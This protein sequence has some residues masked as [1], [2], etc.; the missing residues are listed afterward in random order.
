MAL[1]GRDGLGSRPGGAE[2]RMCDYRSPSPL[3][4]LEQVDKSISY[5]RAARLPRI[6]S[7]KGLRLSSLA[8]I[9]VSCGVALGLAGCATQQAAY[10]GRRQF[11][12]VQPASLNEASEK[13]WTRVQQSSPG[14]DDPE[15]DRMVA[16]I[17]DRLKAVDTDLSR[18]KIKA[19]VLDSDKINAFALPNG[20][21]GLYR[22]LIRAMPSV[23]ALAFVM[24]HELAHILNQHGAE[25]VSLNM[26]A[27]LGAAAAGAMLEEAFG[28]DEPAGKLAQIALQVGLPVALLLP[29]SREMESEADTVGQILMS[30]AGF[31][32]RG[33][34][35]GISALKGGD[36]IA[37]LSTHPLKQERIDALRNGLLKVAA[38]YPAII[39]GTPCR[40][41]MYQTVV[42]RLGGP[43]DGPGRHAGIADD[44]GFGPGTYRFDSPWGVTE[45][46]VSTDGVVTGSYAYRDGRLSGAVRDGAATVRWTQRRVGTGPRSGQAEFRRRS[47]GIDGR[48][49]YNGEATWHDD[50]DGA[51]R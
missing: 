20:R 37:W 28:K 40:S 24:A 10:T 44:L 14:L 41:P 29:N 32:L 46:R 15:A 43:I 19:E 38:R 48:W 8:C 49:R 4:T 23:D 47:G 7:T 1:D 3:G 50:W 30:R 11:V 18:M 9:V 42:T 17:V 45:L 34:V 51:L 22:G 26:A 16:C 33:S 31:D 25:K 2:K 13:F 39:S 35:D 36:G 27:Q 6:A 5:L 21:V 12:V